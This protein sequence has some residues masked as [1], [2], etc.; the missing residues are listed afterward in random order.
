MACMEHSCLC[1]FSTFNNDSRSPSTC[2]KCGHEL[3]HYFDEPECD[4]EADNERDEY[5]EHMA[6]MRID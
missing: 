4:E 2:P 5:N 6:A 1:G 3:S